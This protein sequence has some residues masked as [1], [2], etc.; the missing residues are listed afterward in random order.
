MLLLLRF[1]RSAMENT[2][3]QQVSRK[4]LQPKTVSDQQKKHNNP[5]IPNNASLKQQYRGKPGHKYV[6]ITSRCFPHLHKRLPQNNMY[7]G[8]FEVKSWRESHEYK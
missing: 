8:R 1:Q 4:I 5:E 3:D 6:K 7:R 2:G